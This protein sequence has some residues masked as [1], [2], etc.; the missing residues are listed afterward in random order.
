[1]FINYISIPVFFISFAIGIL[2]V[3]IYGPEYKKVYIYP[4]IDTINTML[5]RDKSNQCF[6]LEP[7]EVTCPKNENE[8]FHLPLQL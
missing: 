8:Y 5:Y 7:Q 6:R 3:Y 1:M 4:S 2:F